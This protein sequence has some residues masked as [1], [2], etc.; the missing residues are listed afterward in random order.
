MENTLS[1]KK[2]KKSLLP[3]KIWSD[4]LKIHNA[5]SLPEGNSKTEQKHQYN[6]IIATLAVRTLFHGTKM[7]H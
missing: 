6:L 4:E 3:L 5:H 2:K 7:Q 1:R